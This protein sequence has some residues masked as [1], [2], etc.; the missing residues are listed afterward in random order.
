MLDNNLGKE[1]YNKFYAWFFFI[2]LELRPNMEVSH[3]TLE[4]SPKTCVIF[5]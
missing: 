5:F 1:N 4:R 2:L 3:I